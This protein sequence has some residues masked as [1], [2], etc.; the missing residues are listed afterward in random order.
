MQQY[1]TIKQ[2]TEA[3]KGAITPR[4]VR[5]YHALGLLSPAVRSTDLFHQ[6][7]INT[8][9]ADLRQINTDKRR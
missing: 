2:L 8:K 5:H 1:L 7:F 4:M 3:V 6:S 9:T